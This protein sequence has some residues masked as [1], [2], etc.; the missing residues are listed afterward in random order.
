M[1]VCLRPAAGH[2]RQLNAAVPPRGYRSTFGRS[3]PAGRRRAAGRTGVGGAASQR[4]L[5]PHCGAAESGFIGRRRR[6]CPGR[7]LHPPMDAGFTM[8]PLKMI[9][10]DPSWPQ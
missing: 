2:A 7:E 10:E 4:G 5:R 1:R 3:T 9:L 8:R 6:L